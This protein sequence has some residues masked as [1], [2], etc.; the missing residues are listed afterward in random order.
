MSQEELT[1]EQEAAS[2]ESEGTTTPPEDKA[3]EN[4]GSESNDSE[5][6]SEHYKDNKE[7]TPSKSQDDIAFEKFKE[8]KKQREEKKPDVDIKE[9]LSAIE[10]RLRAEFRAEKEAEAIRAAASSDDEAE[11]IEY[12]L[13]TKVKRTDNFKEDLATAKFLANKDKYENIAKE[14][15]AMANAQNAGARTSGITADA[16]T[17]SQFSAKEQELFAKFGLDPKTGKPLKK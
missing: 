2:T 12:I 11:R 9:E 8:R 14:S 17:E 4:A 7:E 1:K 15:G 6:A 10:A 13:E 3:S 16:G 5:Q